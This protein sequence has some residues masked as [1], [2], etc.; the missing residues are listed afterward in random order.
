M[1]LYKKAVKRKTRIQTTYGV[2]GVEAL[3]DLSIQ[4]LDRLAVELQEKVENTPK[5]SFISGNTPANTQAKFEF[6]LVLDV[7]ETKIKDQKAAKQRS[8]T[9]AKRNKIA[10]LIEKK[11]DE[12]LENASLEELQAMLED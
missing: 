10:E 5:K 12:S 6:N 8:E 1:D 7:L 9:V 4:D 3:F 2:V 11:K